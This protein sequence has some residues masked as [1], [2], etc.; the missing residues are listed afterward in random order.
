MMSKWLYDDEA[1]EPPNGYVLL[2][3]LKH[4]SL[5]EEHRC[6]DKNIYVYDPTK[7]LIPRPQIIRNAIAKIGNFEY[8]F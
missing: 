6:V 2:T 5:G 4:F 8:K 3:K 7:Y 1:E